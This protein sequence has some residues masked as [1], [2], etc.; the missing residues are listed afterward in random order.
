MNGDDRPGIDRYAHNPPDVDA[1]RDVVPIN[2]WSGLSEEERAR[3]VLPRR[4][5]PET[6]PDLY[7]QWVEMLQTVVALRGFSFGGGEPPGTV[8]APVRATGVE[9]SRNWSGARV[10]SHETGPFDIIVGRWEAPAVSNAPLVGGLDARCSIWVGLAGH[11]RWS[12]ALPQIGTQHVAGVNAGDP[13]VHFA[14]V[15]WWVRD[16]D[17]TESRVRMRRLA[18]PVIAQGAHVLCWIEMLTPLRANFFITRQGDPILYRTRVEMDGPPNPVPGAAV[19]G[20]AAEWIVERPR[21]PVTRR[22]HPLAN[23][24]RALFRRCAAGTPTGQELVSACRLIRMVE[25]RQRPERARIISTPRRRGE[26]RGRLVVT[27]SG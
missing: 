16:A 21:D 23:Y 2:H 11:R 9:S 18:A 20:A 24:T 17:P 22:F 3:I 27:Y 13:D 14:W 8:L 5:R 12:N 25:H 1:P 26:K 6:Q 10:A 4:P 19:R 15:Q 7:D